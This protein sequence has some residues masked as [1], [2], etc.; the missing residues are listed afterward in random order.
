MHSK[1]DDTTTPV[2]SSGALTFRSEM[3]SLVSGVSLVVLIV[4][5]A[6]A[7]WGA[8]DGMTDAEEER[9]WGNLGV[10][11][12]ALYAGWCMLEPALRRKTHIGAVMMRL[13]SACL[14]APA[15]VSVPTGVVVG[16]AVLF[17][18]TRNAI[19]TAAANN[20]G[21]HYYW[22][23]GIVAQV[24]LMPLAGWIIGAC[25]ALGV[26]LVL[27]LPILSIRSPDAV[28][29]GSHIEK[30][31]GEKRGSTSAFVFC[32]LGATVLG[33]S[34]WVFGDGGSILDFPDDLVRFLG[35]LARG[36]FEWDQAMWL[37]GVVFVVI[38]VAAMGWGC[39]RVMFARQLAP[40]R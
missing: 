2:S 33:I 38:G 20:G 1:P 32:G 6:A 36:S 37:F 18:A 35:W 15:F 34:L 9:P 11:A 30:V 24:F 31:D 26:A 5:L 4:A 13:L 16:I 21:F 10:S 23:E 27:S 17:P 40:R 28:A 39:V 25:T 8:F 14:I 29:T 7:I 22:S 19:T 3:R 12:S